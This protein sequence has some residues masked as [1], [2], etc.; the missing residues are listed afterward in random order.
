MTIGR[1]SVVP[2]ELEVSRDAIIAGGA[3]RS[4]AMLACLGTDGCGAAF[5]GRARGRAGVAVKRTSWRDR[6][7][8]VFDRKIDI[9]VRLLAWPPA[10][11]VPVVAWKP[12]GERISHVMPDAERR[13]REHL[14][15]ASL[16]ERSLAWP[17]LL[18]QIE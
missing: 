4:E 1:F 13:L 2:V 11:Y 15:P 5:L 17:Q 14:E 9:V 8:R 16:V 12:R 10:Y 6:K 7:G 18:D 3:R